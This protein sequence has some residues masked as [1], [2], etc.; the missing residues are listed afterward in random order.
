MLAIHLQNSSLRKG[1]GFDSEDC[2][3][4]DSIHILS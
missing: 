1:T 4:S 3:E 2:S